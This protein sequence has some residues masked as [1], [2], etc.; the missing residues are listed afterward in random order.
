M[1]GAEEV[2]ATVHSIGKGGHG[3]PDSRKNLC[4][5][6]PGGS[7]VWV[8]YMD[9]DTAH[10]EDGFHHRMSHRPTGRNYRRG[11]DGRWVYPSMAEAM[12]EAVLQE[13]ETYVS[14]HQNT[15][16][17]FIITRPIMDL[18]LAAEMRRGSRVATWW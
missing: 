4:G 16:T 2:L 13:V 11:R 18:C 1:E 7:A 9:D 12:E 15:F 17:Q 6:G 10:F 3:C 5:G 14:L 8:R